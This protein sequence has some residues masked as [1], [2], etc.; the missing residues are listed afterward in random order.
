[1]WSAFATDN[2]SKP[3]RKEH[4]G[5]AASRREPNVARNDAPKAGSKNGLQANS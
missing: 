2:G 1:M 4:S 5:V 3:R